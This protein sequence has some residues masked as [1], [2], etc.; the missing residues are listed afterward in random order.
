M[1]PSQATLDWY[2]RHGLKR[3]EHISHELTPDDIAKRVQ[4]VNP[5]NWRQEGNK[6]IA[7]TDVGELVNPIPT[8]HILTGTD[9]K[10]LPVFKKV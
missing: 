8:S 2:D 4:S 3:P 10:G 6:L 7:D 9:E 1:I 5:R